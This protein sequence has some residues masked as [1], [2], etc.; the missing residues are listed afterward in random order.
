MADAN[1]RIDMDN[2]TVRS[3]AAEDGLDALFAADQVNIHV[4]NREL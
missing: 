3:L 4:L 1:Y 2:A